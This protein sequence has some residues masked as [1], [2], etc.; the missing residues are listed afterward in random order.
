MGFPGK[1][2][3]QEFIR[4]NVIKEVTKRDLGLGSSGAEKCYQNELSVRHAEM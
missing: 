3:S 4:I 1:L 2:G